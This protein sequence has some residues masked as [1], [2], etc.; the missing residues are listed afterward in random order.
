IFGIAAMLA[1]EREDIRIAQIGETWQVG[2]YEFRLDDVSQGEGPNYLTTM[3]NISVSHDGAD[4]GSLNPEKRFYQVANMPTTEAAIINGV[5]RDVYVVIGDPQEDG[6][7]A[8][9]I[10]L[11][12]FANWIWGGAILMALGGCFSL[13]DRRLR[14]G[15]AAGRRGPKP[16]AVPAE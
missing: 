13:T 4:I 15:A 2:K 5:L 3:A 16:K 11:K 10:Y 1:W 6:G 9:R 14:V 7:W 12:P 8:V